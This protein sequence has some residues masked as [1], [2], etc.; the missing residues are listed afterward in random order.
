MVSV[1][2]LE[3]RADISNI[4]IPI[5]W[6]SVDENVAWGGDGNSGD[7]LDE[8]CEGESWLA[9]AVDKLQSTQGFFSG[10]MN[11]LK[12]IL[13]GYTYT[14]WVSMSDTKWAYFSVF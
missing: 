7:V 8:G 2:S 11:P 10:E 6:V 4:Q 9:E 1:G 5:G 3:T 12:P 13:K 14:L